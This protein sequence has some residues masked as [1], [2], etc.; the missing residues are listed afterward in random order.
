MGKQIKHLEKQVDIPN[1]F[2]RYNP[3]L[4]KDN[5]IIYSV[6]FA[7][8]LIYGNLKQ[9]NIPE[10]MFL[11]KLKTFPT[12]LFLARV[13]DYNDIYK[14]FPEYNSYTRKAAIFNDIHKTMEENNI[15]GVVASFLGRDTIALFLCLEG[16]D[17]NA[18][19]TRK[20]LSS[21]AES[22]INNVK[23]HTA[24]SIS[25]GISNFSNNYSRFP[26]AYMEC[27]EALSRN[28]RLGK[29]I[30]SFWNEEENLQEEQIINTDIDIFTSQIITN[31]DFLNHAG[32]LRAI[33]DL[34]KYI[35]DTNKSSVD[36]RLHMVKLIN[37]MSE[38]YLDFGIDKA[39]LDLLSLKAIK[40]ILNSNFISTMEKTLKIFCEEILTCLK[41]NHQTPNDKI[42]AFVDECFKNHYCESDFNLLKAANLCHYSPY[43]FGR[44]FK[45]VYGLSFNQY[46]CNFRVEK[47]KKLLLQNNLSIENVAGQVGF[48]SASCFCTVFK[49]AM[50]ISPKQYAN[51]YSDGINSN[52]L[53]DIVN[54]EGV[55]NIEGINNI[56]DINEIDD[57][58]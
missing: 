56:G 31:L 43:H 34:I 53:E 16:K 50:G 54:I 46:L 51:T 22:F 32:C 12:I 1:L 10:I 36:V 19:D 30:Y 57:I 17:I 58:V 45:Q 3:Y 41:R 18:P 25:I 37:H 15:Q 13:D 47:S 29:G 44:L 49:K 26:K 27:K 52:D 28:W 21:L 35:C 24:E 6:E 42:T 4:C 48:G 40:S 8:S 5:Y 11:L 20:Y 14:T 2:R 38:Y 39:E 9:E 55:N 33:D 23:S 7:Y